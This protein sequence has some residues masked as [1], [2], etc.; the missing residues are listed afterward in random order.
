MLAAQQGDPETA[1]AAANTSTPPEVSRRRL[2]PSELHERRVAWG[3]RWGSLI[4]QATKQWKGE[5]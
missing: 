2:S 1:P 3:K 5:L 4:S